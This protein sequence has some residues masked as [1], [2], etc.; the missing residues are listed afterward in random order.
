MIAGTVSE[1]EFLS[2]GLH[3]SLAL[4]EKKPN[5]KKNQT[6]NQILHMKVHAQFL[7]AGTGP[8]QLWQ[9]SDCAMY[10]SASCSL[11]HCISRAG[12]N[13]HGRFQPRAAAESHTAP[14]PESLLQ[15]HQAVPSSELAGLGT[16]TEAT[17]TLLLGHPACTWD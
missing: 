9:Q 5:I 3:T 12:A 14:E 4:Q 6:N 7:E 17:P 1:R 11:F 16:H 2:M 10:R 13:H 8:V 15:K